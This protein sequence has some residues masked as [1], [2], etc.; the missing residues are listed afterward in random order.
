MIFSREAVY[1]KRNV[2]WEHTYIQSGRYFHMV[3]L[4]VHDISEL[5]QLLFGMQLNVYLNAT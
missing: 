5:G 4:E 2:S 1:A 3:H